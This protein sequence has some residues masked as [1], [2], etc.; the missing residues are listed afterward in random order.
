MFSSDVAE[1]GNCEIKK[2]DTLESSVRFSSD[3]QDLLHTHFKKTLGANQT[4]LARMTQSYLASK[5]PANNGVNLIWVKFA[6][7]TITKLCRINIVRR[8]QLGV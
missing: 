6:G 1:S 8:L 7:A 3:A 2:E 4:C 5:I